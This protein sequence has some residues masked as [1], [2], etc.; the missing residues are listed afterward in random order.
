M[1]K[2]LNKLKNVL[3]I[4]FFTWT[5]PIKSE[6]PCIPSPCGPNSQCRVVGSQAAC[7]CLENYIG[8]APNCRPECAIN[9]DCPGNLACI[10]ERCRD[11][12]PGSCGS[13]T[14]CTVITHSPICQC[15]PGY[16]GDPFNG[17]NF[18]PPC[19]RIH[20]IILPYPTTCT[21]I[22]APPSTERP[23]DPCNPSPCG[24]NAICKERNG[25][26]SCTC[27]KE[28]FGDPYVGCRPECVT[29]SDC[30]KSKACSN[31]KCVD[32]CPGTCGINAECLVV[33]HVPSCSC[34]PGYTGEPTLQCLIIEPSK[35]I[36]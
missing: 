27:L 33:N 30:D 26:G 3:S 29:N 4:N 25:A 12:C 35:K 9:E 10:K 34:I 22:V 23:S 5:E 21:L 24:S 7:S 11:P 28:Y 2:L 32:P 16:S 20:N 15:L 31:N 13:F 19:K 1:V 36:N 18:V 14:T 6:N 17:C 8:R